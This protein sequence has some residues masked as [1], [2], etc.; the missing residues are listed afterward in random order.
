[1]G[2]TESAETNVPQRPLRTQ[3]NFQKER[4]YDLRDPGA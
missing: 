1:M 4:L 2:A 3:N